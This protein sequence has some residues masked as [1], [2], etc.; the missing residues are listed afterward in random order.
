MRTRSRT[1]P[2]LAALLLAA[3]V[4]SPMALHGQFRGLPV[5]FDPTDSYDT[6]A[7]IDVGHGGEAGGSAA[8]ASASHLF[9]VGNC[10]RLAVSGGAGVLNPEG[11]GTDAN[12]M[13]GA[14]GSVLLNPCPSPLSVSTLT[15][16]AFAGAGAVRIDDR[17]VADA[18]IGL[19][20]GYMLP[21][22]VIRVELW[23]TPRVHYRQPL[24]RSGDSRW[25][26]ALSSGLNLGVKGIGGRVALDC[27]E[28]G[29][30]MGYGLS[31]WF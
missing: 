26:F 8:V 28:D 16:R 12:P 23:A 22:A 18:P 9:R 11:G 29:V 2:A 20:A 6:R 30:G 7:G 31:A 21:I 13:A 19:A 27:C 17:T 25:D 14:L 4:V 15:F 3:S 24:A 5:F 1:R 10:R